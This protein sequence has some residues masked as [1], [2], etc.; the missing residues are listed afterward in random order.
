MQRFKPFAWLLLGLAPSLATAQGPAS[1]QDAV[2]RAI[3]TNPEVQARWNQFRAARDEQDVARGGLRPRLDL[4][5]EAGQH[6][7]DDLS[8]RNAGYRQSG[9]NLVLSQL[10]FDGNALREEVGRLGHQAQARYF[11][12]VD[13]SQNMALDALRA[14]A[15]VLRYRDLVR[16]ARENYVQHKLLADQ[17]A[18][19]VRVG[20]GRRVDVEQATGRVALA[21]SNLLT[22]VSNLHD[23][24]ARYQRLV[25]TVP[26]QVLDAMPAR[27]GEELQL[28]LPAALDL[29]LRRNPGFVAA[30]KNV[31][32]AKAAASGA[33][34][35]MAPRFDL[36]ARNDWSRRSEAGFGS[37][38]DTAVEILMTVNLFKGGSD[39]AAVRQQANQ[40]L[41]AQDL[42]D[43]AC[44][45]IRQ[46][47]AI[48]YHD[49]RRL[50]EQVTYLEQH[51]RSTELAR[52]AYRQQFDI[53]QRSLLD[54]LDT[55]NEYFQASRALVD[56]QYNQD[57]AYARIH[58]ALGDLLATLNASREGLA[59]ARE[60]MDGLVPPEAVAACP[61]EALP[62]AES[63]DRTALQAEV[64]AA[65][66]RMRQPGAAAASAAADAAAVV[67]VPA[68]ATVAAG[69]V[70]AVAALPTAAEST[71]IK[72]VLSTSLGSRGARDVEGKMLVQSARNAGQ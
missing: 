9:G 55:E 5:L 4:N 54:L 3:Q 49:A 45:D 24:S 46:A 23:V 47:L 2:R 53:N 63:L 36:R 30:V 68:A 70:T 59:D 19:R 1:P 66:A 15:D 29:A 10:L 7:R 62:V 48:A 6:R 21:E 67:H 60:D 32:A 56:A 33:R 34:S 8:G 38:R 61:A 71:P 25:G 52:A 50:R 64:V 18:D 12:F 16:L 40:L 14:H 28:D 26:P 58:A 69:P 57:L 43:K 42:R 72:L 31:E 13:A 37:G 65:R 17:I 44:R 51:K 22:E 39:A 35:G 20:A 41:A 11:E 27:P